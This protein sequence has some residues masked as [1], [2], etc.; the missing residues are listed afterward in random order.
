MATGVAQKIDDTLMCREF[1]DSLDHFT[2][3]HTRALLCVPIRNK[4]GSIYGALEVHNKVT[5]DA[6]G[7]AADAEADG[8]VQPGGASAF[9][10]SDLMALTALA[11]EA[12]PC[13]HIANSNEQACRQLSQSKAVL[14]WTMDLEACAEM[15]ELCVATRKHAPGIF[16]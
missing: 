11:A 12:A 3:F 10:D 2:D 8:V 6:S 15:G 4:D 16:R 7:A 14:G 1:D 5:S 13:F 9:F